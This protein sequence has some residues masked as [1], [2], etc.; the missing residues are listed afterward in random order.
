[1]Q[2]CLPERLHR[3]GLTGSRC[4]SPRI[5]NSHHPFF[6]SATQHGGKNRASSAPRGPCPTV[7][8]PTQVEQA[9]LPQAVA[10]AIAV[11]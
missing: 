9:V 1:M 10:A 4:E 6:R 7:Q 11:E 2:G 3:P 5:G 8:L